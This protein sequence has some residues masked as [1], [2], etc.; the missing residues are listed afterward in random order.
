MYVVNKLITH[1]TQRRNETWGKLCTRDIIK[2]I[3]ILPHCRRSRHTLLHPN[4][5]ASRWTTV[6]TTNS[7]NR[8]DNLCNIFVH[9][10]SSIDILL[11]IFLWNTP[12]TFSWEVMSFDDFYIFERRRIKFNHYII[13]P[14][15]LL[16]KPRIHAF[17][18]KNGV[19]PFHHGYS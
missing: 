4:C 9:S 11:L 14:V 13:Y 5:D 7:P 2:I 16:F 12:K 1:G 15:V 8:I 19:N 10:Q 17:F 6:K 3:F 18:Y